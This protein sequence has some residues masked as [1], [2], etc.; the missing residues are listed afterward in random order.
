MDYDAETDTVAL[1][2]GLNVP[3]VVYNYAQYIKEVGLLTLP[4]YGCSPSDCQNFVSQCPDGVPVE[5]VGSHSHHS[6]VKLVSLTG[7]MV[8][9]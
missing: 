4:A 8:P 5:N 2:G 6:V 7:P 9:G 3:K 1:P